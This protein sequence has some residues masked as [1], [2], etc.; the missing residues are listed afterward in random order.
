MSGVDGTPAQAESFPELDSLGVPIYLFCNGAEVSQATYPSL[1]AAIGTKF[2]TAAVGKFKLPNMLGRFPVG[3]NSSDT[4]FD[5][6]GKVG[7]STAHSHTLPDHSHTFLDHQHTL[8]AHSHHMQGHTHDM[9]GHTHTAGSYR[10]SSNTNQSAREDLNPDNSLQA[11]IEHNHDIS[12]S[13]GGVVA[14]T[15]QSSAPQGGPNTSQHTGATTTA[16]TTS[17]EASTGALNSA[18]TAAQVLT[19]PSVS[20]DNIPPYISFPYIIKV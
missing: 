15:N 5:T 6:I 20:N 10:T 18:A 11:P 4:D 8:D 12:G 19:L 14:A 9:P 2:G 17:A 16:A 3:L 13:T 1:F 7:T